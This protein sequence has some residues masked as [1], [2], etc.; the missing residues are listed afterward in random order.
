MALGCLWGEDRFYSEGEKMYCA[1][2]VWASQKVATVE[3]RRR[4][5]TTLGDC[6]SIS[7]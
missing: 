7:D 3:D 1:W 2:C 6:R 4:M 5:R